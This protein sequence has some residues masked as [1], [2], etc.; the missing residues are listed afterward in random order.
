MS[1]RARLKT[2][3]IINWI[4]AVITLL[5][6]I[7]QIWYVSSIWNEWESLRITSYIMIQVIFLSMAI[8]FNARS[9]LLY[10][11]EKEMYASEERDNSIESEI[12]I[13]RE[14]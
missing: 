13:K 5:V 10:L 1:D 4:L 8:G 11:D 12:K 7:F 14:L 3:L 6:I 9:W 2:M